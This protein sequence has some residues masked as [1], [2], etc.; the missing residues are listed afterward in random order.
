M[1]RPDKA[2]ILL[3][4]LLLLAT[5]YNFYAS[6]LQEATVEAQSQTCIATPSTMPPASSSV[7]VVDLEY[8]AS[9]ELLVVNWRTGRL[10]LID[11][12]GVLRILEGDPPVEIAQR[13]GFLSASD[14]A[15]NTVTNRLYLAMDREILVLDGTT[16]EQVGTIAMSGKLSVNECNNRILITRD[17]VYV[18]D[19]ETN[20]IIGQ[21]PKTFETPSPDSNVVAYTIGTLDNPLTSDFYVLSYYSFPGGSSAATTEHLQAYDSVT[22]EY[23]SFIMGSPID[24]VFDPYTGFLYVTSSGDGN[25]GPELEIVDSRGDTNGSFLFG[26]SLALDPQHGR[27]YVAHEPSGFVG[28]FLTV[29]DTTKREI[30]ATYRFNAWDVIDVNPVFNRLILQGETIRLVNPATL[31]AEFSEVE[32]L[33]RLD[34]VIYSVHVTP[35]Y[36]QDQT[37]FVGGANGLYRSTDGGQQWQRVLSIGSAWSGV[38]ALSPNYA[39]DH[40]L[41]VAWSG[42]NPYEGMGVFK[43]SDGGAT[44]QAVNGG[45]PSLSPR[46]LFYTADGQLWVDVFDGRG[47]QR[48]VYSLEGWRGAQTAAT[49]E[50][51]PTPLPSATTAGMTCQGEPVSLTYLVSAPDGITF[52]IAPQDGEVIIYSSRLY[53][54]TNHSQCWEDTGRNI[55]YF[56]GATANSLALSPNFSQDQTVFVVSSS[57]E[58]ISES[59]MMFHSEL[60]KSTDGGISWS[61]I[62]G[63]S[64]PSS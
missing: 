20:Q 58:W 17:G 47:M 24:A 38:L 7:D 8:G 62:G 14:L 60:Y 63:Q 15:I 10:A 2:I 22:Y 61:R 5:L 12:D 21:I 13:S 29:L 25:H 36:G 1:L 42:I 19:G 45:L 30:L 46:N 40:T 6:M 55:G 35:T 4:L 64:Y 50:Y 27:L 53:R 18:T 41:A 23:R 44:W 59:Q 3:I 26:G 57:A 34:D 28:E 16:G 33:E 31:T 54:S 43:S 37:V 56:M 32:A 52:A 39:I 48:L 49:P 9:P 11:Y 51:G